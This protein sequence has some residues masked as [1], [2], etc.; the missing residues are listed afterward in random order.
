MFWRSLTQISGPVTDYSATILHWQ[1]N[2]VPNYL[3]G[4]IG[5]AERPSPSYIVDVSSG[6]IPHI[7]CS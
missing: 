4:Y 7:G 3:G 1:H 5:E 2:R 6:L